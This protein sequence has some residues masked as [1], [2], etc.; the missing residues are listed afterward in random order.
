MCVFCSKTEKDFYLE[1]D[2]M[3]AIYNI[4]PILPGHSLVIPKRHV[5]SLYEPW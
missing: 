1:T 3:A 2:D 4:S 5:E